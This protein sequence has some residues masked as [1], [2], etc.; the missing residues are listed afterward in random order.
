MQMV[1]LFTLYPKER[2]IKMY[3]I[4]HVINNY[5]Y[6]IAICK[7]R[8]ENIDKFVQPPIYTLELNNMEMI[9]CFSLSH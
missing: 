8:D 2:V 5:V 3:I 6:T 9:S 4:D 7:T 1:S